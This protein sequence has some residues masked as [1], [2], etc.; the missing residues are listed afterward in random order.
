L[1]VNVHLDVGL[2][3][4]P[5]FEVLPV[6]AALNLALRTLLA[7]G[8]LFATLQSFGFARYAACRMSRSVRVRLARLCIYGEALLKRPQKNTERYTIATLGLLRLGRT[9]GSGGS[10]LLAH[11]SLL[12]RC[13]RI[14]SAGIL[15]H[16]RLIVSRLGWVRAG[17]QEDGGRGDVNVLSHQSV[18]SARG[19]VLRNRTVVVSAWQD[20]NAASG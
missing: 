3:E 11:G 5:P 9:I 8:L 4:W 19:V 16:G 13:R 20:Y 15:G 10:R 6:A 18:P 14:L 12:G 2:L 17:S 1:P 7:S